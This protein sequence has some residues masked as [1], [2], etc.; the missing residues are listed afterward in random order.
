MRVNIQV[1]DHLIIAP[2]TFFSFAVSGIMAELWESKKYIPPHELAEK[3][4]KMKE[5]WL[6]RG[7]RRGIRENKIRGKKEG[8]EKGLLEG[9]Q[10]GEMIGM[11]KGR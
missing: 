1:V 4:E 10:E 11:E 7:M 9:L 2:D 6:E 5:E 8:R 3:I